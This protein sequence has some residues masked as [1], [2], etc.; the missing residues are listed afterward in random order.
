LAGGR[1][2]ANSTRGRQLSKR[3]KE[4]SRYAR[5][6]YATGPDEL[7]GQSKENVVGQSKSHKR[8][9]GKGADTQVR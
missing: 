4:K 5:A 1:R 2:V 3:D 7:A 8:R 9:G 6:G